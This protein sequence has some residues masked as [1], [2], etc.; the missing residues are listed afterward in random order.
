ML[1][2]ACIF[3]IRYSKFTKLIVKFSIVS[4]A[5]VEKVDTKNGMYHI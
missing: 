5:D 4:F 2:G 3:K 1:V